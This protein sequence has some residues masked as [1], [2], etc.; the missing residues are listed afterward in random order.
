MYFNQWPFIPQFAINN[1]S[2]SIWIMHSTAPSLALSGISL[3]TYFATTI[4]VVNIE[5]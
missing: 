4:N 2:F 1:R 3:M 5:M